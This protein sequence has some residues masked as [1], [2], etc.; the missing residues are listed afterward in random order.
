IYCGDFF[1]LPPVT[2]KENGIPIQPT[3]AFDAD[4][5]PQTVGKPIVLKKVFRQNDPEFVDMLNALRIGKLSEHHVHKF[6]A[7]DRPMTCPKGME[8]VQLYPLKD[9]VNKANSD[10]LAKLKGEAKYFH[11]I[12]RPGWTREGY[13]LSVEVVRTAL[14]RMVAL[15]TVVLKVCSSY[16]I[17]PLIV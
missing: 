14:S 6:M 5:W 9:N 3:L 15:E 7:L 2:Q 13:R 1:Q 8:P 16:D 12:D 10:R 17:T 4:S 11:S